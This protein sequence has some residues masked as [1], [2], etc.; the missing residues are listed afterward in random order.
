MFILFCLS[1]VFNELIK[2]IWLRFWGL[3]FQS[4]KNGVLSKANTCCLRP[5]LAHILQIK[6]ASVGKP[7]QVN[8]KVTIIR[9]RLHVIWLINSGNKHPL[10]RHNDCQTHLW[11]VFQ[12][13]ESS[14]FAISI[15]KTIWVQLT[16]GY[17]EDSVWELELGQ[18]CN[19]L[20]VG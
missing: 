15:L 16:R 8:I 9:L 14:K 1:I 11:L 13:K 19:C 2:S 18:D 7:I 5:Y 17:L 12:A 4:I 3:R 20:A 10:W 6:D